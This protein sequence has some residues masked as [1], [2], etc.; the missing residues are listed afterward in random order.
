MKWDFQ[1]EFC[2]TEMLWEFCQHAL[3]IEKAL[4]TGVVLNE[5]WNRVSNWRSDVSGSGREEHG[6]TW[7][8]GAA[9]PGRVVW[10]DDQ[11]HFCPLRTLTCP[12]AT[13]FSGVL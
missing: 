7:A 8:A 2:S 4:F 13:H 9:L 12:T 3:C 10:R 6:E 11:Y 5:Q 1:W